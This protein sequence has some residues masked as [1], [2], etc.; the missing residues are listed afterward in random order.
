[1]DAT[2]ASGS[3]AHASPE[4]A[5]S[6]VKVPPAANARPSM[7]KRSRAAL[8]ATL[9]AA[10][11]LP[12]GIHLTRGPAPEPQ[13]R[14]GDDK[15]AYAPID[16]AQA[17][18]EA[19]RTG[20]DVV[21]TAQHTANST[22]WAQPDGLLRTRTYSDTIRAKVGNE[23][24]KIDTTLRR[25]GGGYAP[26]AVND[27]LLFSGG[28]SGKQTNT[29]KTFRSYHRA[30]LQPL[31]ATSDDTPAWSELVRLNVDGHDLVVSWP[32]P[33][34]A[35]VVNDSRALYENVRPG[36]DLLLTARDSGYSHVLIVHSREAAKDP[37]LDDLDYRLASP[38]LTFTL[39]DGS[40][41][42]SARDSNGQELAAAPTPYL[43]DSAGA[44][45]M[46]EG[47]PAPTADSA[48]ADTALALPGLAGPQPGTHDAILDATLA[49]D[50]TLGLAMNTKVLDDPD[51]VYPVFIDPSFKGHKKNWTLLYRAAPTSS[52]YNGQNFNDGTNDARVGYEAT[53]GGLSRSVFSFENPSTLYGVT[54]K[55]ATFRALQTYS[56]GCSA[57]QYD[58]WLTG[59][60]SS[61]NTWN[62][63][64]SWSRVLGS[65]TNGHGY[66]ATSCPDQWVAVNVKSAA[67]DAA[68][69]K[70]A[71]LNLGLRAANEGDTN[72][73]KKF[74]ANGESSPYIET[75]YNRPP[76]EPVLSG[77]KTTPGGVCDYTSPFPSVG[78]SDITFSAKGSDTDGNLRYVHV[79]IWPTGDT[80]HALRDGNYTPTSDG[81][82]T[83]PVPSAS[84]T[85]G[86][87]YTWTAWSIDTEGAT[88]AWGPAGTTAYCQF[89][90]DKTAP[91]SPTVSS[92]IYPPSGDDF[93]TWSTVL[94]RTPGLFK[95]SV[96]N[97]PDVVKYEYS[98]NAPN[99]A[100]II[101]LSVAG[102]DAE[103]ELTPPLAGPN[104]LYV[105]VRDKAGN[106]SAPR[107]YA[108]FVRPLP[109]KDK[110]GDASGDGTPDL[111]AVDDKGNLQLYAAQAGDIDS[112]LPAS[113]TT[114]GGTP[115]PVEGHWTGALL[116][117]HSDWFPGDGITDM[118]ARVDGELYVYPGD[119]Y[120]SFDIH[121]RIP[122]LL[123]P[124]A[125]SPAT[126]DQIVAIGDA[127]GDGQLDAMAT[128]T[129]GDLWAFTGYTGASFEQATR[130][131]SGSWA[132]RDIFVAGDISGDGVLDLVFRNNTAGELR[133]RQGKPAASGGTDLMSLSSAAASATPTDPVYSL[134]AGWGPASITLFMGTPDASGDGIP[135]FWAMYK[136][137]N[138]RFYRGGR[139]SHEASYGNV[140]QT[141]DDLW[142]DKVAFG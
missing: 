64:P 6:D 15:T 125:P 142:T 20:R 9:A 48:V 3:N 86:K 44:V 102:S 140:I 40:N 100:Q 77:M 117:H 59:G 73:W 123:P 21:V 58:V 110:P 70:W 74:M 85:D 52:F 80:A 62:N 121:Q 99:Y 101:D 95:F 38:S 54:I 8:A 32:G 7:G 71:S 60:I 108:F 82:V 50:G 139:T 97:N 12:L 109:G 119:G 17:I 67:Q 30:A 10:V 42:V 24:K 18:R 55:S 57:R 28:S 25:V 131:I 53:T 112:G 33:L 113:Y 92:T 11:A 26:K 137:G 51:T 107:T 114:E 132:D 2:E 133:L 1:M 65:Q 13:P 37:L 91:A 83:V 98:F 128:T 34:P 130:L 141:G 61:A 56:W 84:F 103:K 89:T 22:T 96:N 93:S 23:W 16:A 122:V 45:K 31:A 27:P 75:V 35:P 36:I 136:T 78:L 129:S 72:A 81:T 14:A 116:S 68:Y 120:G 49:T 63:Q 104:T 118:L 76:N 124:G 47:E 41:V 106:V 4:I 115:E 127:T 69:G 66:N 126:L 135:D 88:S 134:A 79:K 39:N 29:G 90:V 5:E 105:R 87:T 19:E 43:W 94:H 46:T 138:V 111:Y